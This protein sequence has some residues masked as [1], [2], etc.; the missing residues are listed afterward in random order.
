MKTKESFKTLSF[1]FILALLSSSS[2]AQQTITVIR[3]VDGD[4]LKVR[5]WGKEERKR[6]SWGE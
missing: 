6:G 1:V 3:I 4:T 2:H 5:Y